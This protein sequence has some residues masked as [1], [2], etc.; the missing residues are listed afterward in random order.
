MCCVNLSDHLE[1]IHRS[2]Q[3]WKEEVKKLQIDD[4]QGWIES[5][6]SDWGISGWLKGL[7]KIGLILLCVICGLLLIIPCLLFCLQRALQRMVNTAFLLEKQKGGDVGVS[8]AVG[9][10]DGLDGIEPY[11]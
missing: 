2:L 7:M 6:F 3:G 10:L 1:S 5:L 9:G 4:G 11:L 8:W